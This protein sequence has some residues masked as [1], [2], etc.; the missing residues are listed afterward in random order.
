VLF[1]PFCS[2]IHPTIHL[3][4]SSCIHVSIYPTSSLFT[5]LSVSLPIY[6]SI[7]LSTYLPTYLPICLSICLSVYP[8]TYE[9][10]AT[11]LRIT[12]LATY[13]STFLPSCLP[14]WPQSW[15]ALALMQLNNIYLLGLD[16]SV[17]IATCYEQEG[18]GIQSRREGH[19][20]HPFKTG[21]GAHPA[22]CTMGTGSF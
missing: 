11:Y 2:Y 22:S 4:I 17:R 1:W 21:P 6:L 7:Y 19:F 14:P 12:H 3:L 9:Y 8:P 10:V 15:V 20:L 13:L 16:S 5:C 18:P